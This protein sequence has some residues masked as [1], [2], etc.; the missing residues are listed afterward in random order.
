MTAREVMQA[1]GYTDMNSVRPRLSDLDREGKVIQAGKRE[2]TLT[3]IN[4]TVY[5]IVAK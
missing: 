2:D 3:G 1:L 5:K 4:T